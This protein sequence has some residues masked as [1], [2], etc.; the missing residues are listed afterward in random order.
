MHVPLRN[1]EWVAMTVRDDEMSGCSASR[2]G[3]D[4]SEDRR[5]AGRPVRDRRSTGGRQGGRR[6]TPPTTRRCDRWSPGERC[7]PGRRTYEA[8]KRRCR[9]P[10]EGRRHLSGRWPVAVVG[11][12]SDGPDRVGLRSLRALARLEGDALVLLEGAEPVALNGRVV[13]EDVRAVVVSRDEAEALLGVE[14]LD[15]ALRHT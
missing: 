1:G 2:A 15:G 12:T 14:P 3:D 9:R 4:R 7:S 8:G 6:R 5:T 13:D 10:V 11:Q